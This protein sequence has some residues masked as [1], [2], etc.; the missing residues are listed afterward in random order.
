[1]TL[2]KEHPRYTE[3]K[4]L[5]SQCRD[6]FNGQTAVK[7][8]GEKYLPR[9]SGQSIQDYSRYLDRATFVNALKHTVLGLSGLVFR[10]QPIINVPDGFPLDMEN[11]ISVYKEFVREVILIGQC[12]LLTNIEDG[13]FKLVP[14]NAESVISW[15]SGQIVISETIYDDDFEKVDTILVLSVQ[16]GRYIATRYKKGDIG[17][18]FEELEAFMP[19]YNGRTYDEIP[20]SMD[21]ESTPPLIDLSDINIAHYKNYADY[22][23]AIH[24]TALPT[25]YI[26]GMD[27]PSEHRDIPL[28]GDNVIQLGH[29]EQ[30]GILE[31]HG[32]GLKSIETAIQQ[33]ESMMVS[34]GAT[35]L[36]GYNQSTT[37]SGEA[38]KTRQVQ[39]TSPLINAVEESERVISD[40]L[41]HI[42]R[43]SG[44][45]ADVVD[46]ISITINK[47]FYE[48]SLSDAHLKELV[49][50]WQG[51]ALSNEVLFYNLK[52]NDLIP[53]TID[54]DSYIDFLLN[55]N[56]GG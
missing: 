35:M 4:P 2:D 52:R 32:G 40:A 26:T 45:S 20:F 28:G 54:K 24:F 53:N 29:D 6:N 18:T 15:K 7:N 50:S 19:I 13:I 48:H 22:E 5:W 47:N 17:G 43:W 11:V 55:S 51:G 16:K 34:L 36:A 1:M 25:P 56:I 49:A 30:F 27:D 14:Y 41:K 37:I 12:G 8:A 10:R 38:L 39:A 9:L 44:Y 31:Y 3:L 46:D 21:H 23:Q 42:G 33:K